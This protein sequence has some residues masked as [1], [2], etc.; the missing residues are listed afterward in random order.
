MSGSEKSEQKNFRR[1]SVKRVTRKFLQVSR[2]V[3]QNNGNLE[4]Y[5]IVCCT[6]KVAF[7]LIRPIIVFHEPFSL[8]SSLSI[9]RY[10]ILFEK[11]I[12]TIESFAFSPG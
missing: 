12:N 7:S 9:T 2:L 4:M 1:F 3:V 10:C 6:C 8:H 11:T 5:K